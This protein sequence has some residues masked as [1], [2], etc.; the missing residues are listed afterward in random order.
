MKIKQF[1]I[2]NKTNRVLIKQI[3]EMERQTEEF[4]GKAKEEK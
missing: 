3:D 2:L 1:L 4:W